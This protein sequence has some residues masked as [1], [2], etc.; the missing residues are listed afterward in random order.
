[1]APSILALDAWARPSVSL[2]SD[3]QYR[4]PNPVT[5]MMDLM[6]S[7]SKTRLRCD[8]KRDGYWSQ[9]GDRLWF[10]VPWRYPFEDI[11]VF[12]SLRSEL[13]LRNYWVINRNVD[14]TCSIAFFIDPTDTLRDHKSQGI[15][16]QWGLGA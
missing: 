8:S 14:I 5:V 16:F 9:T 11:P 7:N 12:F 4:Y 3:V 13:C 10:Q 15:Q 2:P 6:V 1:M